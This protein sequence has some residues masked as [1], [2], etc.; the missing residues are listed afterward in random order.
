MK[1]EHTLSESKRTAAEIDRQWIDT[2]KLRLAELRSGKVKP[3]PSRDVLFRL[4]AISSKQ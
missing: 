3:I 4:K 2:A 1:K